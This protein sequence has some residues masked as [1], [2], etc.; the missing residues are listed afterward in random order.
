MCTCYVTMENG[1]LIIIS[2]GEFKDSQAL[3]AKGGFKKWKCL[4]RFTW[5]KCQPPASSVTLWASCI[6]MSL[7]SKQPTRAHLLFPKLGWNKSNMGSDWL[8]LAPRPL[9]LYDSFDTWGILCLPLEL[10]YIKYIY[11]M[12]SYFTFHVFLSPLLLTL[13]NFVYFL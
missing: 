8:L 7:F 3:I 1:P 13:L 5:I 10:T 6:K 9:L 11:Y 4:D 12:L 2:F